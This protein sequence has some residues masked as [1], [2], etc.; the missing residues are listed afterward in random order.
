M[1]DRTVSDLSEDELIARI[2][3]AFPAPP[4]D[5]I[6]SGDDAAVIATNGERI[7]VT[8]DAVVE[9]IDFSLKWATGVDIGYKALAVNVSDVAAMG[10]TPRHAVVTL[11]MPPTTAID[12]VD[13]IAEGIALATTEYECALIGGDISRA[14]KLS[15]SVTLLGRLAGEPVLRSGARPGD[16]ICVTGTLGA[17]AAGVQVLQRGLVERA[18]IDAEIADRSGASGLAALAARQLRPRARV[19][20]S[21]ILVRAPVAAMIDISD[22]LAIDLDRLMRASDTGCELAAT[23]IP[24]DPDVAALRGD[25]SMDPLSTALTGGE[26]FELLFAIGP[27]L[28]EDVQM[29]MDELGT[30]ITKIGDV[31]D[32]DR[33]IDGEPLANHVEQGWDHLRGR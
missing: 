3:K 19:R 9:D 29:A 1:P 2:R 21:P 32:G 5:E 30:A 22:G 6:W 20:E 17:A 15:V 14:S 31:T 4:A 23:A 27:E 11:A 28:L 16:A 26:D 8:T 25:L 12:L 24:I 18:A 10:A 33:L 7:V 13:G